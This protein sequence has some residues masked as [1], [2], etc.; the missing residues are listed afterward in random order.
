LKPPEKT[1]P[2][3]E[4]KWFIYVQ[5]HHEGPFTVSEISDGIA[6]GRFSKEA[7][8]WADGMKDWLSMDQVPDFSAAQSAAPASPATPPLPAEPVADASASKVEP[9]LE[10]R[11]PGTPEVTEEEPRYSPTPTPTSQEFTRTGQTT[12]IEVSDLQQNTRGSGMVRPASLGVSS[13]LKPSLPGS[14]DTGNILAKLKPLIFAVLIVFA[15]V[16]LQRLG[17]LRGIEDKISSLV[18]AI[19]E[20]TDV[21]PEDYEALKKAAK[22]SS[23][24]GPQV[25]VA[26]SKADPLSPIFYVATNLPEGARFELYIEGVSQTLLNTLQ[27]SGKLDVT[28]TKHLGKSLP[29]R[30]PDGKPI[31]RGEYVVYAME[32]PT[33]QPDLVYKEL[34]QLAPIAR[35]L[36]SHLPQ[37]RRLVFSKKI[38][39]GSKDATYQQRLKEFHDGLAAK[40]KA[41]VAELSQAAA[42]LESQALVSTSTYDRLKRQ[43]IGVPQKQGWNEMNRTWRPVQAQIVQK[44]AGLTPEQAK[45][46]YFHGNLVL[47]F[48]AIE[49]LLTDLH[50]AQERLFTTSATAASLDGEVEDLRRQFEDRKARWKMALERAGTNP[51]DATTGLPVHIAIEG[52]AAPAPAPTTPAPPASTTTPEGKKP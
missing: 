3:S 7:Y 49:K 29:L 22:A 24:G 27:F 5:D 25:A 13:A 21:N 48:L 1:E 51:T 6:S 45:E 23:A 2:M 11:A 14:G 47:E 17:V 31:P 46:N 28:T 40:A 16:G 15:L 8:V 18:S 36:P 38:F 32:A 42:T 26:L 35:K 33:G 34:L 19:P 43:R 20:L 4:K 10:T 12:I 41:E 52:A 37:E 39:F 30:Y 9:T 50:S 44:Y